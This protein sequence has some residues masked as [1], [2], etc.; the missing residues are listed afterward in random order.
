MAITLLILELAL[1][2]SSNGNPYIG[3]EIYV[4]E[5]YINNVSISMGLHPD[6]ADQL[7]K[8]QYVPVFYWIDSISKIGNLSSILQSAMKQKISNRNYQWK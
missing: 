5:E 8:Y 4:I 7:Q 1:I 3:K 2:C 6:I